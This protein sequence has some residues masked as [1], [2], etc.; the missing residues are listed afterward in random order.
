VAFSCRSLHL[1]GTGLSSFITARHWLK[2]FSHANTLGVGICDTKN[3]YQCLNPALATING[4]E[5][6][7]HLNN[8]IHDI[9]GD[10]AVAIEP[11]LLKVRATGTPLC[12]RVPGHLPHSTERSEWVTCH[13]PLIKPGHRKVIG[14]GGAVVDITPLARMESLLKGVMARQDKRP[15]PESIRFVQSLQ[16]CLDDYSSALTT[17][18]TSVVRRAWQTDQAD[19]A[20]LAPVI[21]SMDDRVLEMR[22][23]VASIEGDLGACVPSLN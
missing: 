3:R 9:I 20:Q 19:A 2:H 4:T 1:S 7:S 6:E 21:Q 5:L 11:M 16:H 10:I 23:L 18:M 13:V 12:M 17:T 8:T 15:D 14:W 22:K